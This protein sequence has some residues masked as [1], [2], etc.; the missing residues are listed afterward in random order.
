MAMIDPMWL[1][2]QV[3]K[4]LIEDLKNEDRTLRVM[5]ASVLG[6]TL[7]VKG[8]NEGELEAKAVRALAQALKDENSDVR[9]LAARSLRQIEADVE[10]KRRGYGIRPL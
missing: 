4:G 5:S 6:K 10:I 2:R 7:G 8:R 1:K 9:W 3:I